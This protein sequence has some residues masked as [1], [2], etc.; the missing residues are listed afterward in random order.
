MSYRMRH[1]FWLNLHNDVDAELI[2][3]IAYLK[4]QKQFTPAIR[5]GLRLAVSLRRGDTQVLHELFPDIAEMLTR[6]SLDDVKQLISD[7]QPIPTQPA[8]QPRQIVAP[9]FGGPIIE[10]DDA[11]MFNI[12]SIEGHSENIAANFL[13]AMRNL[14]Q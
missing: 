5:D 14:Q 3:D 7:I 1:M 12:Q 8:G 13:S 6:V 2:D 9:Q 10:E 11:D 4:T